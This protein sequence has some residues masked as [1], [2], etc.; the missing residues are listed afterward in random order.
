MSRKTQR[1]ARAQAILA[2]IQAHRG[3]W[4][5]AEKNYH[6]AAELGDR[7]VVTR[8]SIAFV[9]IKQGR[10]EEGKA[11]LKEAE[12]LPNPS[13]DGLRQIAECYPRIGE[14]PAG[15]GTGFGTFSKPPERRAGLVAVGPRGDDSAAGFRKRKARSRALWLL[16][17]SHPGRK[18][19]TRSCCSPAQREDESLTLAIETEAELEQQNEPIRNPALYNLMATLYARRE[20]LLMA[21]RYLQKS[22]QVDPR[23]PRVRALLNKVTLNANA[24]TPE[25]T[26]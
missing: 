15:A 25:P 21:H 3:Q 22:L 18:W 6:T 5:D 9:S 23:Q 12:A 20:Q 2:V 4:M 11:Y 1:S 26:Q 19:N 7:S 13:Q 24:P 17:T 10:I 8:A 16:R 14:R